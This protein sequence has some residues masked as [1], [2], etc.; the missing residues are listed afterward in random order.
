M[1]AFAA[2]LANW[3]LPAVVGSRIGVTVAILYRRPN[4]DA[5]GDLIVKLRAPL[6]G[7]LIP[8]GLD[9]PVR[10]ARLAQSGVHVGMLV[11]QHFSKGVEVTFSG[12]GAWPIRSS[13]SSPRRPDSPICGVRT[14]RQ[15]D[16]NSFGRRSPTR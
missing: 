3:E 14:V 16:G 15:P 8:T 12:A 4:I 13:R 9:A 5:V 6:M 11:D 1:L 7:E 10:L 2:H